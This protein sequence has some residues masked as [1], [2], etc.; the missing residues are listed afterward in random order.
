MFQLP[1]FIEQIF[2]NGQSTAEISSHDVLVRM[3]ASLA[4]GLISA[5]LYRWSCR[6][7]EGAPGLAST[8]VLLCILIAM[9]TMAIGDQAAKAF[10]L[11]GTLAIVRF[12]TPVRDI[13]DTAF[14]ILAVA[15]GLAMGAGANRVAIVG[16]ILV[17]LVVLLLDLMARFSGSRGGG[18]EWARLEVRLE[19]ASGAVASLEKLLIEQQLTYRILS[20]RRESGQ[21]SRVL[22]AVRLSERSRAPEVLDALYSGMNLKR[23]TLY[24]A[25]DEDPI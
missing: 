9:V 23:A 5:G 21:Q 1:D 10:T 2:G 18:E 19:D 25:N 4:F 15:L 16:T 14:V 11:V 13:R 12:R 7:R 6:H 3:G 24:F 17:A 8:L 20:A 22:Y